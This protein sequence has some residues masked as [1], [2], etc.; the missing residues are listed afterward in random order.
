MSTK[1]WISVVLISMSPTM[2]MAYYPYHGSYSNYGR[3]DEPREIYRSIMG[4]TGLLG[5]SYYLR[6]LDKKNRNTNPQSMETM[7]HPYGYYYHREERP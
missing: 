2:V 4:A 6:N 7:D 1:K 3:Y 5:G